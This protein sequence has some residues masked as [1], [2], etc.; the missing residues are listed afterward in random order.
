MRKMTIGIVAVL[1]VLW[2]GGGIRPLVAGALG[3]V[4]TREAFLA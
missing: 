2:A 4:I 1:S 3:F